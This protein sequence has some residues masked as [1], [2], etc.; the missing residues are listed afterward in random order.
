M[1]QDEGSK[2]RSCYPRTIIH[3]TWIEA[4]QS[5]SVNFCLDVCYRATEMTYKRGRRPAKLFPLSPMPKP[6]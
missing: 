6:F 2:A 5:Q 3:L 1:F 4:K